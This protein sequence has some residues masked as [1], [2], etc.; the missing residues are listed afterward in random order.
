MRISS[1]AA[2]IGACIIA[3][4]GCAVGLYYT[5]L[6][7][8]ILASVHDST[9]VE[10]ALNVGSRG[11]VFSGMLVIVSAVFFAICMAHYMRFSND[12]QPAQSS[13]ASTS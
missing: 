10:Q 4:A 1:P 8:A 3:L 2:A 9:D 12:N 5:G 13:T 11:F 7:I 6:C